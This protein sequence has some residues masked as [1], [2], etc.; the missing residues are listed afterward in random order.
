MKILS[1][2]NQ[3]L[4]GGEYIVVGGST[5]FITTTRQM[6]IKVNGQYIKCDWPCEERIT[7]DIRDARVNISKEDHTTFR[8]WVFNPFL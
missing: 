6:F 8:N 4:V 3:Q 1:Y 5:V 7:M 2:I